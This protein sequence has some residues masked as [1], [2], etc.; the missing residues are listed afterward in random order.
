[1]PAD[2]HSEASEDLLCDLANSDLASDG[3]YEEEDTQTQ[4]GAGAGDSD[5]DSLSSSPVL[6]C[7]ACE[8]KSKDMD[9]V[10]KKKGFSF[11]KIEWSKQTKRRVQT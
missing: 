1:M 9:P 4:A 5:C 3:A 10:R 7:C 8:A 11:A 6:Q 2:N